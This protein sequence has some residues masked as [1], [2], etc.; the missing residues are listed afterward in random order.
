MKKEKT[1]VK[2]IPEIITTDDL[3]EGPV[4]V[5][6]KKK[7]ISRKIWIFGGV[8]LV[9][10]VIILASIINANKA[11]SAQT[12]QTETI[13]KGDLVAVVGATGNVRANQSDTLYWLV[14]GRIDRINV[15]VGD[16]VTTGTVL[17]T[18]SQ[19]SLPQSVL[20]AQASLFSAQQALED[21]RSSG[22]KKAAAAK[23]LADAQTAYNSALS[24]YWNAQGTQGTED[25]IDLT[26]AQW[27]LAE[28]NVK[29]LQQTYDNMA[30]LLDTDTKKAQALANLT[31]A[32]IDRDNLKSLLDYYEA[33]PAA[34]DVQTLQA[35]LDVAKANLEDA[36]REYDRLKDGPDPD[37]V[38]SAEANVQALEASIAMSALKAPFAGTVTQ[39]NSLVGDPVTS[40]TVS[41]RID[42]LSKLM[43]DIEVP[44][45]DINSIK[46]GQSATITFDAVQNAQY[47]AKVAE[48]ARVGDAVGGVVQ[49]K[50]TLQILNADAQVLPGM[51]A[52]VNIAVQDKKDVLLAP[53]RAI[54]LVN[55]QYVVYVV[56][57]GVQTMVPITIGASSDSYSEVV[58][59]DLRVGDEVILNPT[60]SLIDLMQSQ[61][62]S[63][64]GR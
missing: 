18:L 52:A 4:K 8:A 58:S 49:F 64:M 21:A 17:A 5:P 47:T 62:P 1:T 28:N 14:S 19:D 56:R 59:G 43:V 35:K 12:F 11:A 9:V 23:T 30:E 7:T 32:K 39:V 50:V 63:G 24:N 13:K 41:F 3:I 57:D 42:D 38:A 36:Q 31:Q 26:R 53:N 27:Q 16:Q 44:E 60:T 22:L 37:E 15:A 48:V 33:N 34:L 51:T 25:Q 46:V 54:R 61:Q 20:T 45:V 2:A 10:L 55:E 40:G 29:R 6:V